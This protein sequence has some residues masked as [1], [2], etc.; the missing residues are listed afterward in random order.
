MGPK[1][2]KGPWDPGERAAGGNH[3]LLLK[4][5][6][7][8]VSCR[9]AFFASYAPLHFQSKP[10]R[11][12]EPTSFEY[13]LQGRTYFNRVACSSKNNFPV[14][15]CRDPYSQLR[16]TISSNVP[17]ELRKIVRRKC[18][19]PGCIF[20]DIL[21]FLRFYL[22]LQVLMVFTWVLIVLIGLNGY[23]NRYASN[24]TNFQL[25]WSILDPNRA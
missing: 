1:G 6:Y 10:E 24:W 8:L 21:F 13:L 17:Q 12:S 23:L 15:G 2:P 18:R 19:I 7:F 14:P 9:A 22:I 4:T 11:N 3:A 20:G 25:K 5:T 16:A